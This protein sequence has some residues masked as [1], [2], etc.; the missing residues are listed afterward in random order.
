MILSWNFIYSQNQEIEQLIKIKN[1]LETKK[2]V[3]NDSINNVERRISFLKSNLKSN[4]KPI[5]KNKNYTVV[6]AK[7]AGSMKLTPDPLGYILE[8]FNVLDSVKIYE[9]CG[10]YWKAEIN[11][12]KGKEHSKAA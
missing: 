7:D 10:N 9:Y 3:L 11:N 6:K 5:V 4:L 2:T 1:E 8:R 12:R